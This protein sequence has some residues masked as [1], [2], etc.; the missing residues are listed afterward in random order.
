M[1]AKLEKSYFGVGRNHPLAMHST[2]II[3][4]SRKGGEQLQRQNG[5]QYLTVDWTEERGDVRKV[6]ELAP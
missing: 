2:S 5:A 3:I 6:L 1:H 4:L